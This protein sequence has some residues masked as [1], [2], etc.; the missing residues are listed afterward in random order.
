MN[1]K[2]LHLDVLLDIEQNN[3]R[4]QLESKKKG[5]RVKRIW[6]VTDVMLFPCEA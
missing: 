2:D 6:Q 3:R 4:D 5:I 1:W